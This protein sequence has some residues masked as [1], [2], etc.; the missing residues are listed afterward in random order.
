MFF[1]NCA[2]SGSPWPPS[3]PPVAGRPVEIEFRATIRDSAGGE[4]HAATDL[5]KRRMVIEEALMAHPEEFARIFVHE[6]F[7]FAWL[8]LGNVKRRS[9]EDLVARELRRGVRGELGW[10]AEWRKKQLASRDR[11]ERT[12][13]WREYCCESF[14]D[15]AAWLYAG[16]PR[17][18]EFTLARQARAGRRGWFRGSGVDKGVA[19]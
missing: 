9:Y 16:V 14:C 11:K 10:S 1:P 12:R 13:K 7:H 5:R 2:S 3:I 17:H 6:L 19:I 8:R 4:A 15:T 18:A